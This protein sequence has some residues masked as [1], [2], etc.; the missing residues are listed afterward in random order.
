MANPLQQ[1]A[2]TRKITYL[3]VIAGLFTVSLFVRGKFSLPGAVERK[4]IARQAENLDLRELDLGDAELAGSAIRLSLTGMR[5]VV[6]TAMWRT[7]IEKQK[8]H[9]FQEMEDVVRIVSRLQPHFITPW[10]FQGWNMSYNVSVE[11]ERLNDMYFYIARGLEFMA[12]GERLN[13]KAV[14]KGKE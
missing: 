4:T 2:I 13:T 9:E 5:G 3:V 6:T 8:R 11:N 14:D 7:A 1:A 10:I 12:E